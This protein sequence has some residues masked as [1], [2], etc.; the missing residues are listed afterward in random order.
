MSFSTE[1]ARLNNKQ[2]EA[3]E[4]IEGPVLVIA[5]PG[6]GK[7]QLLSMRAANI[8]KKTDTEPRNILCLTF[9]N[10]AATNMRKR[11]LD[12]LG[13]TA[14]D[15]QVKTFHSF[16][17]EI[18]S[19]Y[20]IYFWRGASLQI[21]PDA[22]Q[23][24]FIQDIL[25]KLPADNPLSARFGG[26]FIATQ[27]VI[28]AIN[29]S[30]EAGLSPGKL[31]ALI[32]L[33]LAYI[34]Q[35]QENFISATSQTL[36]SKT[37]EK[38]Q[39]QINSLPPQGIGK[40]LFPIVGLDTILKTS[41]EKAIQRDEGTNKTKNVGLWKKRFLQKENN[42]YGMY[43][44]RSRNIWWLKL[45]EVY[46][47]YQE[48]MHRR[49]H[50][51]YGDMIVE[52]LNQL[53]SNSDLLTKVQE[54]YHYV[55]IDEF[56]DSNAAQLRLSHL[57][58][59]SPDD[60]QPNIMAVGDDDQ[61]IFG[62]N[63]AELGSMLF[64][65]NNYENTK[66]V[67]I[68]ENYRS[69][70]P[71]LDLSQKVIAQTE[72]RL[73]DQDPNLKKKLIAKDPPKRAGVLSHLCYPTRE[74][75]LSEVARSVL[76]NFKPPNSLAVL[77]RSH[78]SL[79]Q[80]SSL[81]LGLGVP[82]RY[83]QQNNILNYEA[84]EQIVLLARIINAIQGGD[85][86]QANAYIASSLRHP[87]WQIDPHDL[88]E[89]AQVNQSKNDWLNE[90]ENS[91]DP[92]LSDISKWFMWL[93]SI[94]SYEPLPLVMEY[95]IGLRESDYFTSPIRSYFTSKKHINSDYLQALS[96]IRLLRELVNEF[97]ESSS[98]KLK[99]FIELISVSEQNSSGISDESI[100]VTS[101][102]TVDLLTVHKAKGLEYDSV[103]IIDAI[104]KF[105]QPRR[106]G[107][108]PPANLPLEERGEQMDDYVRLLYVALTRAKKDIFISSYYTDSSGEEILPT[109]LIYTALPPKKLTP[110]KCEDPLTILE[111]N[112]RWPR[113]D[114]EDEKQLLKGRVEDFSINVSNLLNFLDVT[115]GGPSY[116]LERNLLRLPE[117]KS[118]ELA[119][120][121]A[122]HRTM[123]EA[124]RLQNEDKFK[125]QDVL[126]SFEKALRDESIQ[127]EDKSRIISQ[128]NTTL[129]N[130]F[131]K[132][133][134]K[135]PAN[136][137][138]EQRISN[139]KL[140][141]AI[142]DGKL[143]RVD[144]DGENLKI[145]DYKTG[146]PL[147]SL[148]SKSKSLE[149]KAWKQRTQLIFY[150]LLARYQPGLNIYK[151]VEGNM[152]YVQAKNSNQ[153]IKSFTPSSEE[154][155]RLE[156]L[157][158]AVWYKIINLDLPDT[159]KYTQDYSGIKKFEEDL[160]QSKN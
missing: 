32:N 127:A 110:D 147:S 154:I 139:I 124:G 6:T 107:R 137:T 112:I 122:I 60:S 49:G 20:S 43:D 115:I 87:M 26:R 143:D 120:G 70:Q 148:T 64:F 90:L 47:S 42:S 76:Q 97:S 50:Y 3:V 45:C 67:V 59:G 78:E 98:P 52:V 38:L 85:K 96:G 118:P 132:L 131:K 119:F 17:A 57:I 103:Y 94:S 142:I 114:I 106:A 81:L 111:E 71:I 117:L 144:K 35:I 63:G 108:K 58:A 89:L 27:D 41:L 53:D 34:D 9:T 80:L 11:L 56:Q 134:Y 66:K 157:I 55:M 135:L 133:K 83:E 72:I 95:L 150:A 128:G 146:S 31:K 12:I 62:F 151:V 44:E 159:S 4:A 105:W 48:E 37:I 75:Q 130:L 8:L 136:S 16:A 54:Y 25:K 15:I 82:I 23:A 14:R 68:D 74:H 1:F 65:E 101:G 123:E 149:I 79:R 104:E 116:F 73:V 19:Q 145:I 125:L 33:N 92:K 18:M 129:I 61:S 51:D 21:A 29:R 10:K 88:W 40:E 77:A 84:I 126:S 69:S 100:F 13:D 155:N 121:S 160:L 22:V 2:R 39:S 113:L 153:L 141:N 102:K 30:K 5:G 93:A 109:P 140:K 28:K 86:T 46:E 91:K 156:R 7:T 158:E 138:Y 36:S 152:V 24:K 99:D